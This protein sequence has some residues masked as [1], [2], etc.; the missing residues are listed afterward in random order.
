MSVSW[1]RPPPP[2]L[3]SHQTS[4]QAQQQ[5]IVTIYLATMGDKGLSDQAVATA[6]KDGDPITKVKRLFL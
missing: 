1:Q 6:C 2:P 4:P 5:K 3:S